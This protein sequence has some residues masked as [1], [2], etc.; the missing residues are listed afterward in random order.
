MKTINNEPKKTM[1]KCAKLSDERNI[2]RWQAYYLHHDCPECKQVLN[3]KIAGG[4]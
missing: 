1:R 3:K 4:K 2:K